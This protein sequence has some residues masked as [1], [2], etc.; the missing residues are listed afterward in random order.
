M[1]VK[2]A[3]AERAVKA[4]NGKVHYNVQPFAEH[5]QASTSY[6]HNTDGLEGMPPVP[7]CSQR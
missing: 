2:V 4:T 3:R 6:T 7:S 1:A 5:Y